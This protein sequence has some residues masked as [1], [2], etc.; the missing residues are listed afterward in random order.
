MKGKFSI[1]FWIM[2]DASLRLLGLLLR[3][4]TTKHSSSALVSYRKV[5]FLACLFLKISSRPVQSTRMVGSSYVA[6]V[7]ICS[8]SL[9]WW[10]MRASPLLFH[11]LL[12]IW[13]LQT[14][15]LICQKCPI[16]GRLSYLMK[17]STVRKE[18]S[19][20]KLNNHKLYHAE[21]CHNIRNKLIC[22]KCIAKLSPSW[23]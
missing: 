4:L 15:V 14:V 23:A 17:P 8:L 1:V 22:P 18:I 2:L 3:R 13:S 12:S 9:I 11:Y 21:L 20:K 5:T 10:K 16:G 7:W 6:S 19:V